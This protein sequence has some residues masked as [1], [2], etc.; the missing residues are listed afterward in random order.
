MRATD[1][2]L[3]AVT[4]DT[5][6]QQWSPRAQL[7]VALERLPTDAYLWDDD[8]PTVCWD[9]P[10]P[11]R[12][13]WDAPTIG[14]GFTDV[15]CDMEGIEI[16]HGEPD[17]SFLIPP[18]S[19]TLTLRDPDGRYR[20]RDETGRLVYY[21]P[22]KRL[23]VYTILTDP[24]TSTQSSWWL[25]SGRIGT[26]REDLSGL[27]TIEA[28]AG[29]A[30][31]A[32]DP[33]RDWSA[34]ADNDFA[35]TRL[36]AICNA[37]AYTGRKRFDTGAIPLAL[38][39]SSDAPLEGL[40]RVAW[41]DGG[42]VYSDADDTVIFRDR[43][44]RT[45]RTDQT[46]VPIISDNVAT[47]NVV[48]WELE[49]IEDD[50]RLAAKVF[51]GNSATPQ[52]TATAT[53][54]VTTIG[55]NTTYTHPDLDLWKVQGDGNALA[56]WILAARSE[57]RMAIDLARIYLHDTRFDYWSE[58]IDRRIG[59]VVRFWHDD[60]FFGEFDTIDVRLVLAT[61]RHFITPVEWIVEWETTNVTAFDRV[62]SW[63][64]SPYLWDDIDPLNV[65][66]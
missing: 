32:Q 31:L 41:S 52:L 35:G 53:A 4:P 63:D 40:Q 64:R 46:T 54:S 18:S 2:A 43:N 50:S 65:W 15:W 42:I 28:F 12:L 66:R 10:D 27:V 59:D 5:H 44:W 13:V 26:W 3:P 51:L 1:A 56:A 61:I 60:V 57:S 8:D 11:D 62:I 34:G 9:D 55:A 17:E 58:A 48:L 22:G 36:N 16:H 39:T 14:G 30:E 7:V 19:A 29:T 38:F 21:S 20:L 49:A 47:A 33:G 23:S 37:F 6:P 24:D 45:G 25:F